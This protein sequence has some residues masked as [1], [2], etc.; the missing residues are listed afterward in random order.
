MKVSIRYRQDKWQKR[1]K[2]LRIITVV[3][4]GGGLFL[5]WWL[6]KVVVAQRKIQEINRFIASA[7]IPTAPMTPRP[8]R[9]KEREEWRMKHFKSWVIAF[10][11]TLSPNQVEEMVKRDGIEYSRLTDQQKGLL[12]RA[13]WILKGS[14]LSDVDFGSLKVMFTVTH[15]KFHYRHAQ[16]GELQGEEVWEIFALMN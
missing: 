8:T 11:K 4:I 10:V 12:K 5:G 6:V 2:I 15:I 13:L 16:P 1:Q 7:V 3:I 9:L 14:G